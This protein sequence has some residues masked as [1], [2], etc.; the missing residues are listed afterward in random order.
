VRLLLNLLLAS[1]LASW[2]GACA[3]CATLTFRLAAR[4]A[5]AP[6]VQP[7]PRPEPGALVLLHGDLGFQPHE[8]GLGRGGPG[9]RVEPPIPLWHWSRWEA[10]RRR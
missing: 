3:G 10:R 7:A 5:E 9:A 1:V 6:R 2:I 8:A 4:L